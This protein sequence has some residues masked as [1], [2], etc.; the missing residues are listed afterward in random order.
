MLTVSCRDVGKDCDYICKG[1]TEEEVM[2]NAEQHAVQEGTTYNFY[3]WFFQP[4]DSVV[5]NS[6]SNHFYLGSSHVG[7]DLC[8]QT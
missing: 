5:C 7:C 8:G 3:D 4:C 1:E 2:K 6:Q